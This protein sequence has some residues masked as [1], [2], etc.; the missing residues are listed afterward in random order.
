MCK[1]ERDTFVILEPFLRPPS[2]GSYRR[3]V[4]TLPLTVL[5]SYTSRHRMRFWLGGF[6]R[7]FCVSGGVRGRGTG[8]SGSFVVE[9]WIW[10]AG[11]MDSG[12]GSRVGALLS[13]EVG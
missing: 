11:R 10:D 12:K 13:G 7:F 9:G 4:G 8:G 5:K 6:V 1:I 3:L 2:G